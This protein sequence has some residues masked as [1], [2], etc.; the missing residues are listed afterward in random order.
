MNTEKIKDFVNQDLVL[1]KATSER[2]NIL[3][4]ELAAAAG[5]IS[6]MRL[7]SGTYK[8][9]LL[10]GV[11]WIFIVL[12]AFHCAYLISRNSDTAGKVAVT[13][14]VLLFGM[15]LAAMAGKIIPF[16]DKYAECFALIILFVTYIVSLLPLPSPAKLQT[17]PQPA[18]KA[19]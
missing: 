15:G 1:D 10:I 4:C 12:A 16:E 19:E 9:S 13:L 3:F 17:N 5:M 6:A 7:A 8:L 2:M 11:Y 14:N 18:P